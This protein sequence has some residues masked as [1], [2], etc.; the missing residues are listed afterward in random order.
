M[1]EIVEILDIVNAYPLYAGI[2]LGWFY[3]HL[4]YSDNKQRYRKDHPLVSNRVKLRCETLQ[5]KIEVKINPV[6]TWL[7]KAIKKYERD[8]DDDSTIPS[9][10]YI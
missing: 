6:I 4:Y 7:F 2:L 1:F 3:V 8:G 5:I 9:F 10:I